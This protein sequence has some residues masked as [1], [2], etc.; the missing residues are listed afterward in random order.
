[1]EVG[2]KSDS[3]LSLRLGR[4]SRN[5]EEACNQHLFFDASIQP[6]IIVSAKHGQRERCPL[7]GKYALIGETL[8]N[9]NDDEKSTCTIGRSHLDHVTFGCA[10]GGATEFNVIQNNCNVTQTTATDS[11]ITITKTSSK[12]PTRRRIL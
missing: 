4:L 5:P 2:R 1:M 6:V 10:T 3:I 11:D 9:N 8:E 12:P 7:V